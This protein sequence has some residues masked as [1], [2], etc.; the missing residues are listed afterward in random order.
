MQMVNESDE[1]YLE[2]FSTL[3][4]PDNEKLAISFAISM[5]KKDLNRNVKIEQVHLYGKLHFDL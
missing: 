2:I 5:L 3:L 1:K 4:G